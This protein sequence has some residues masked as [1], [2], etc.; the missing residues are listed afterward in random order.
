MYVEWDWRRIGSPWDVDYRGRREEQCGA[1]SL[2]WCCRCFWLG[3]VT[4]MKLDGAPSWIHRVV[5]GQRPE[6]A[7][8]DM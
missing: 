4:S 6:T 1:D 8:I 3:R 7:G 5:G 2:L